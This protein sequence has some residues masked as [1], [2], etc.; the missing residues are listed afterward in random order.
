M[1]AA[2]A[3][4]IG[5]SSIDG[6]RKAGMPCVWVGD[7]PRFFSVFPVRAGKRAGERKRGK[8]AYAKALREALWNAG[9]VRP[10]PGFDDAVDNEERRALCLIQAGSEQYLPVDFHALTRA[11]NTGLALP[12]G[13]NVQTAM[14]LAGIAMR[15]R[16][17]GTSSAPS[18]SRRRQL[19]SRAFGQTAC[20][21]LPGP[22]RRPLEILASPARVELATNALGKRCSIQLS[23]GD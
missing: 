3:L 4:G 1:S 10:L 18:S 5:T 19:R 11:Y 23:Y 21:S 12:A 17:Y 8:I 7:A 15:A 22:S 6:F 20:P 16:T 9:I 2:R 13:V 14:K